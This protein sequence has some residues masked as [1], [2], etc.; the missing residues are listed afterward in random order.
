MKAS[1]VNAH[2]TANFTFKVA[3]FKVSGSADI[4]IKDIGVDAELA[5]SEQNAKKKGDMA[6]KIDAR[7]LNVNVNPDN[8]DISLK[9]GLV[10]K[11]ANILIPLIKSSVIP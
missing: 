6:P 3:F 10:S 9:G 1:S 7:T 11:I 8:V 2:A 5:L 4:T